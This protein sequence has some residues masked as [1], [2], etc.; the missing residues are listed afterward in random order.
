M[1]IH[2]AGQCFTDAQCNI[3]TEKTSDEG[4]KCEWNMIIFFQLMVRLS[5]EVELSL[6][7][8][9]ISHELLKNVFTTSNNLLQ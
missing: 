9:L 8:I 2:S 4:K 1:K 3:G 7:L 6:K 5:L